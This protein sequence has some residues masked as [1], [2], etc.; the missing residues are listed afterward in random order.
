MTLIR[1]LLYMLWFWAVSAAMTIACLPLLLGP[2]RWIVPAAE[3]WVR[4]LFW[5][6]RVICGLSWEVRGR[7]HIPAGPALLAGKHLSMWDTMA[8][9]LV[10][11]DPAIIL[12]RELLWVP[13]YGGY[14]MKLRMIS[15]DRSAAATALRAMV[16]QAKARIAEGRSIV[17]FPEGT[18]VAPGTRGDY[19]PGV[20]ALYRQLDVP[21]VP[22][23]HNSGVYWARKGPIRR[24]GTI[25]LEFL[26]P[27]A[28]GM[29]REA[30]MARLEA[31]IETAA[32]RLLPPVPAGPDGANTAR[33]GTARA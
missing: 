8:V 27:I 21:C 25:V 4:M 16:V 6:A 5:G 9:F 7:E 18:R 12:K 10:V 22:F 28:P 26:P 24:P 31:D 3:L 32:Q 15:I 14:A 11:K 17:I 33:P 30:F 1:S 2:R 19:K 13:L 23:A 29:K 20:A